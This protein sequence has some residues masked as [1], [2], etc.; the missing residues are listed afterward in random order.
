MGEPF[1]SFVLESVGFLFEDED[2]NE[3]EGDDWSSSPTGNATKT[4]AFD[5]DLGN[6]HALTPARNAFREPHRP[7]PL[8]SIHR[9]HNHR[10]RR[11]MINWIIEEKEIRSH[12]ANR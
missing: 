11:R 2:E 7:P 8:I 6:R 9:K 5:S 1:S 4:C 3:D 10:I 12:L